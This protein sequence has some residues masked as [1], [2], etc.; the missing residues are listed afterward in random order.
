MR[1][2]LLTRDLI[3]ALGQIKP[4]TSRL[5]GQHRARVQRRASRTAGGRTQ[6]MNAHRTHAAVAPRPGGQGHGL[7]V[8]S[9]GPLH[10]LIDDR[11]ICLTNHADRR[12]VRA[13]PRD[14]HR[15]RHR[16]APRGRP[17]GLVRQS[18]LPHPQA[19]AHPGARAVAPE[20]ESRPGSV[21]GRVER[22]SPRVATSNPP[23]PRI[24]TSCPAVFAGWIRSV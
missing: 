13:A 22:L 7:H 9:L 10:P 14:V 17:A 24:R 2:G 18:P 3:H 21:L 16:Q 1:P 12:G 20:L 5:Q 6:G 19:A 8:Q 11:R 15:R 23:N 4:A